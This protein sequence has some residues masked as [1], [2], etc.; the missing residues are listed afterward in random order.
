M[1]KEIR[2]SDRK[3]NQEDMDQLL[4][5]S[6]YGTLS[7]IGTNGYP[8]GIP[9]SYVMVDG[10]IYFHCAAGAGS[11]VENIANNP[12]VCF[13]VTGNVE[14]LPDQFST[15]YESVVAF[16]QA[17]ICDETL[18]VKALEHLIG[19]YSKGFEAKGSKYIQAM[20]DKTAVY[21]ITIDHVSGKGR[22]A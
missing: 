2:R 4:E 16:G 17:A 18:K 3:L 6:D 1:F 19:K 21:E 14:T 8:Y 12:K 10:K 20:A 7:M 22:K 5:K 15:R 13:T 11:K 9:I